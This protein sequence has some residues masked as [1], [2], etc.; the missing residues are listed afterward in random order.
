MRNK[1]IAL[2]LTVVLVLCLFGCCS[3][4]FEG[5]KD[6][7]KR[8]GGKLQPTM[9][10]DL[11]YDTNTKIVYILFN[12]CAGYSGYGYMSP[13]YAPNGLPYVYNIQNNSLEE[14]VRED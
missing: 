14:I 1:I 3:G 9:M 7:T 4:T 2:I 5:S 10:Q 8:T 12:E 6:Y 11:Y 13:Y